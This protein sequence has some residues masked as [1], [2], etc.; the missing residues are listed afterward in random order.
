LR[1]DQSNVA[2]D[3]TSAAGVFRLSSNQQSWSVNEASI[4]GIT[5]GAMEAL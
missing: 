4:Y 3:L 5:F 1:A 2:A